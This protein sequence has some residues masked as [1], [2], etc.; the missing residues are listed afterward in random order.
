M[1]LKLKNNNS[2]ILNSLPS[3]LANKCETIYIANC[4][5][6]NAISLV[7]LCSNLTNIYC[8]VG[9]VSG[10]LSELQYYATLHG[11][12]NNEEPDNTVPPTMNGTFTITDWYTTS[13]L[14]ALQ[15]VITG[16]TI[17]ADAN[18][19]I[20]TLLNNGDLVIQT[21][22]S[23]KPGYN[24]AVAII[25]NNNG[26]GNL[27]GNPI[28]SGEG[29]YFIT[30][31]EIQAITT[32]PAT[33]FQG[34]T[35]V[36]DTNGIVTN[37]NTISYPFE[38]F[39]E[40]N[41]FTGL[42][43]IVT[44]L[45]NGCTNLKELTIPNTVT[46]L[47]TYLFNNC[48]NLRKLD[49]PSSVSLVRGENLANSNIGQYCELIVRG[50]FTNYKA[51]S[52]YHRLGNIKSLLVYGNVS[53]ATNQSGFNGA[54]TTSIK[55]KSNLDHNT[56]GNETLMYAANSN[57]KFL[58]VLGTVNT[59]LGG[60]YTANHFA[61]G[62]ITHFGADSV[63]A[64]TYSDVFGTNG[65]TLARLSKI[66]VGDGSSLAHDQSVLDL[67]LAS[68]SGWE[69]ASAKLARWW[70]YNGVYR[71]Y[72]VEENLN[73][74]SISNSIDWPYITR[75]ESYNTIITPVQGLTL[76]SSVTVEMYEATDNG[77]TPETPTNI[78]SQ[79][80]NSSTGE[81]NIP[82]VTGNIIITASAS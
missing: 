67:Y 23:T 61:N 30:K 20:D 34:V 74:C 77:T 57:F 5:N 19:N 40:F 51:S 14:Q 36:T 7:R 64:R 10:T 41:Q 21:L 11:F 62:F 18:K 3:T 73:N 4:P 72:R 60:V 80:Y 66:Y 13:E 58:E 52:G 69:G 9:N 1:D 12:D 31:S 45:F 17:T 46:S 22:D 68:G 65:N 42:V 79:V 39:N 50:N 2:L 37:D 82:V 71:T 26:K 56:V 15:N 8:T 81:I 54:S 53:L 6:V 49:I 76:D 75:G 29:R 25:L 44:N 55:T 48:S 33:Y 32:I 16:L 47:G 59:K 38:Y 35:S 24:P 27:K 43:S 28:I 78:T 70:D 63:P